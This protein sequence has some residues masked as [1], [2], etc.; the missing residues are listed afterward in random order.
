MRDYGDAK[1]QLE[2]VSSVA[3]MEWEEGAKKKRLGPKYAVLLS[4]AR[5]N[6]QIL[7]NFQVLNPLRQS[8]IQPF[9][10]WPAKCAL[11]LLGCRIDE[12]MVG[13]ARL[14]EIDGSRDEAT[15]MFLWDGE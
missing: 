14:D 6:Q 8:Q 7:P 9:P 13:M 11:G 12:N 4:E 1:T 5:P 3:E 10:S 15:P 2:E